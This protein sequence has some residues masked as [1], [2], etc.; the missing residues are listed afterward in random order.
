MTDEWILDS[1]ATDHITPYPEDYLES[2]SL[3]SN[4]T[5]TLPNDQKSPITCVGHVNA[6]KCLVLHNVPCVP[7]FKFRLISISKLV[8]Y[9]NCVVIFYSS[10][11]LIQ[12]FVTKK[13]KGVGKER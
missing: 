4:P 7:T 1:G 3:Q 11:C 5:T 9:Q 10:F 13:L 8:H 2:F 6:N 12:D